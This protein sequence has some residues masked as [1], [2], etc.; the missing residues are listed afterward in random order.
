MVIIVIYPCSDSTIHRP[1]NGTLIDVR[2]GSIKDFAAELK[3]D[4]RTIWEFGWAGMQPFPV[5]GR[6]T[7]IVR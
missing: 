3:L 4:C 6:C 2:S 7:T 5:Q 1:C